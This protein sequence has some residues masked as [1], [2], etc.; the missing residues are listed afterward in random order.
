MKEFLMKPVAERTLADTDMLI[1]I[2]K[3]NS[4][5]KDRADITV[6]DLRELALNFQFFE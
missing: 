5:F 1:N 6:N 4:F 2:I 3:G